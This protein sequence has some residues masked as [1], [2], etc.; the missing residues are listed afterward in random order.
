MHR[1]IYVM[2]ENIKLSFEFINGRKKEKI[3]VK[4]Y[5]TKLPFL[6]RMSILS[7]VGIILS[8]SISLKL[9]YDFNY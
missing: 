8:S 3:I 2:H 6:L 1:S 9:L 5:K 4:N 7:K